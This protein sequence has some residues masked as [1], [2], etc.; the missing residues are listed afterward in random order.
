MGHVYQ[1]T[2][3]QLGQEVVTVVLV[4]NS[5]MATDEMANRSMQALKP[6]FPKNTLVLACPGLGMAPQFLGPK[7]ALEALRGRSLSDFKWSP[8]AIS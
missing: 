7:H 1:A 4:A 3:F 2:S 8:V 6:F 5:A